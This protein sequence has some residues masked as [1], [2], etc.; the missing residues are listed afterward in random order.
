MWG[1]FTG[2]YHRCRGISSSGTT[3]RFSITAFSLLI[4]FVNFALSFLGSNILSSPSGTVHVPG[5][6]NGIGS[7][8]ADG[9][10][11][12]SPSGM[13]SNITLWQFLLE[14]LLSNQYQHIIRWTS[15]EGEF[16]LLNAEE[17]A[18][19]WGMRKNKPNMNYDKLSRALRYYYDKNIIRKV[20]GQKF[21]YKF[22]AFPENARTEMVA[23]LLRINNGVL[24]PRT[25]PSLFPNLGLSTSAS[26]QETS[27]SS[28]NSHRSA[29]LPVDL[30]TR[31]KKD[32]DDDDE[33]S[34]DSLLDVNDD[35][36]IIKEG[37]TLTGRR[38]A[39]VIVDNTARPNSAQSPSSRKRK[40]SDSASSEGAESSASSTSSSGAKD[41][42]SNSLCSSPS[43]VKQA[44]ANFVSSPAAAIGFYPLQRKSSSSSQQH[45]TSQLSQ[46]PKP[47]PLDLHS[48]N[49]INAL[50]QQL[51]VSSPLFSS[52][53]LLLSPSYLSSYSPFS[54]FLPTPTFQ[55]P[56]MAMLNSPI[57]QAYFSAMHL[58]AA[59]AADSLLKT[60]TTTTP[61]HS[62]GA[63]VCNN[64]TALVANK[65]PSSP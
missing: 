18:R 50:Q 58:A 51:S 61:H 17:V 57:N 37:P 30:S 34:E 31:A 11:A 5:L 23:Y 7:A 19:L 54:P 21:V 60:P 8:P 2:S 45:Q 49:S 56:N 15:T 12:M 65:S 1:I 42:M 26:S 32:H 53:N 33:C 46:K 35:D 43:P 24:Q 36:L 20:M 55:Y 27:D 63:K 6:R 14:L 9:S 29:G 44:K 13:D 39:S 4:F 62:I 3:S 25:G 64:S 41:S 40:P 28:D 48:V 52:G 59:M 47:E 10:G 16:K 38:R 22:V